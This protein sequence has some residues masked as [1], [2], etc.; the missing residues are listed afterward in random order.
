MYIGFSF[1]RIESNEEKCSLQS[2]VQK[3]KHKIAKKTGPQEKLKVK[4]KRKSPKQSK[5]KLQIGSNPKNI[6]FTRQKTRIL[7]IT[8][9]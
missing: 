6:N 8:F 7:R 9:I 3:Q 2:L 5:N 1:H 4:I